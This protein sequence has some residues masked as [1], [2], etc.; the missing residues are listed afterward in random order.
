MYACFYNL[1]FFSQQIFIQPKYLILGHLACKLSNADDLLLTEMM[2]NSL[3]NDLK[4]AQAASILSCFVCD[5]FFF[6]AYFY[7]TQIFDF[8]SHCMWIVQ[9]WNCVARM[10]FSK[11]MF[12]GL[13]NDLE[14]AQAASI[15]SC[16]V[17]DE[18]SNE[19]I[20][21]F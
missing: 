9:Y 5:D 2:F 12:N 4:P 3:F 17:C 1:I 7:S 15:L 8:R 21:Y 14:P 18:R 6:S 11:M 10:S 19:I 20:L 13:F 16:F